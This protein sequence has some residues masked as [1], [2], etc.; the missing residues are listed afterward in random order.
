MTVEFGEDRT[1]TVTVVCKEC[2]G[3]HSV[4]MEI[5]QGARRQKP[6]ARSQKAEEAE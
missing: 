2:G 3:T 1:V 4:T 5:P 6:E